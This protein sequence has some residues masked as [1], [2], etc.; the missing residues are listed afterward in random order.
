MNLLINSNISFPPHVDADSA[1]F[2][3][4]FVFTH[5]YTISGWLTKE[6]DRFR[7]N[8]I[9]INPYVYI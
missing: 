8:N 2:L 4:W 3:I 5:P 9:K 1:H 7:N 6:V